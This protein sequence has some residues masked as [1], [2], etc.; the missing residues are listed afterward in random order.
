MES[1]R[2]RAFIY[3]LVISVISSLVCMA[4]IRLG[5]STPDDPARAL[6]PAQKLEALEK[7]APKSPEMQNFLRRENASQRAT[8]EAVHGG[9]P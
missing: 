9:S 8:D 1:K 6:T 4:V 7:A 5:T 3:C 2:S